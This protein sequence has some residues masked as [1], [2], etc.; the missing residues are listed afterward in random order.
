[1]RVF[2]LMLSVA[3][4]AGASSP[5]WADDDD[6]AGEMTISSL[7]GG[8][9]RTCKIAGLSVVLQPQQKPS[10]DPDNSRSL[11]V[12]T[13]QTCAAK[14]ADLLRWVA[15]GGGKRNV[16]LTFP[17]PASSG[18]GRRAAPKPGAGSK[19]ELDG[20]QVSTFAFS[21]SGSSAQE[22]FGFTAEHL[23]INGVQLY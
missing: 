3:L 10:D 22:S 9:S 15:A 14:E 4:I 6:E 7:D 8:P 13:S 2:A 11:N 16:V 17:P 19:Y 20:T 1:M 5:C 23:R 21:Q 18:I 12:M